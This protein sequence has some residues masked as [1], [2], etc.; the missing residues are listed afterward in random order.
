MV[1]WGVEVGG[2][3]WGGVWRWVVGGGVGCGGGWSVM[4]GVDGVEV[5]T[6]TKDMICIARS[7]KPGKIKRVGWMHVMP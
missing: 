7:Y 6:Q 4:G 5:E 1:G 2:G 3:W